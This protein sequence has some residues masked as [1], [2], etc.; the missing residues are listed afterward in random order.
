MGPDDTA[1]GTVPF[2][3]A[4]RLTATI[5]TGGEQVVVTP[6]G[7]WDLVL[8]VIGPDLDE[9]HDLGLDG[10]PEIVFLDEGTYELDVSG[11]QADDFG[12]FLAEVG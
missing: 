4:A 3:G 1:T 6:L 8:R 10:E 2:G 5:A 11:W 12:D 7:D 9:R